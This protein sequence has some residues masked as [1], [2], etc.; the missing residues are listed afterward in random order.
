MYS[1]TLWVATSELPCDTPFAGSKNSIT[2]L[3]YLCKLT[4]SG[5]RDT[6]GPLGC[7]IVPYASLAISPGAGRAVYP[8]ILEVSFTCLLILLS[9]RSLSQWL[10]TPARSRM[11]EPTSSQSRLIWL[12]AAEMTL[13]A[14]CAAC[15]GCSGRVTWRGSMRPTAV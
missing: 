9:C 14:M 8:T 10:S 2:W 5:A 1:M 6:Q 3:L 15:V 7:H 13:A 11:S 4:H 12:L